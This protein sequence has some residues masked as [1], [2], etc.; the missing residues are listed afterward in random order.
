MTLRESPGAVLPISVLI[1]ARNDEINI[2]A[3]LESVKWADERWVVHS[4][5][6][7]RTSQIALSCG[8]NLIGYQDSG[9]GVGKMSWA[10]NHV[11]FRNDWVLMLAAAEWVSPDLANEI[12]ESITKDVVGVDIDCEQVF[13]GRSLRCMRP[14][15]S[16]RLFRRSASQFEC[17]DSNVPHLGEM[18][19][20]GRIIVT[21]PT[22]SLRQRLFRE[23]RRPMRAWVETLNRY[24]D[25]EANL[26]QVLRDEPVRLHSLRSADQAVK[27]RAL[28][29]LWVRLPFRPAARFLYLYGFRAGFMDGR[30]GLLYSLL[31][32]Y[33]EFLITLKLREFRTPRLRSKRRHQRASLL[34]RS[35]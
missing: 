19:L 16:V 27:R 20:D 32:G 5:S 2:E 34:R 23:D 26:Y 15:W 30:E 25:W 3:A 29:H 14:N 6:N 24:S 13:L 12:R 35:L 4:Q 9:D 21:G 11:P 18:E 33:Y 28:K 10:L 1:P 31:M 22:A 7:D 17:V 8:A